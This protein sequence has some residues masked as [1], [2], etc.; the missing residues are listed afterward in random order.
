MLCLFFGVAFVGQTLS[1]QGKQ[2]GQDRPCPISVL[3][4]PKYGMLG[5]HFAENELAGSLQA[6][7]G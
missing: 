5:P 2:L 7:Q 1:G 6:P 3:P 4:C